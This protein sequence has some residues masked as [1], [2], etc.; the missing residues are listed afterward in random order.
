[1]ALIKCSECGTEVSDK[2]A[3]CIKC[4]APIYA[5]SKATAA[6]LNQPK[7]KSRLLKVVAWAFG[8][9]VVFSVLAGI[10][11]KSNPDQ[12]A[13]ADPAPQQPAQAPPAVPATVETPAPAPALY[14]KSDDGKPCLKDDLQCRGN[15][16][17]VAASVY[18]K[19]PVERLASHSVKW[20]DG[21]FELKFS[22]FRFTDGAHETLTYIGDKAEFQNGFGAFTPMIYQCDLASDG[23]TVLGVRAV[24]GRLPA[25]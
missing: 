3:A 1:M 14:G 12:P 11:S 9:F 5:Q 21:T 25:N 7:R 8:I 18:C 2:A 15:A 4:G 22:R 20:T 17:V 6:P 24:D 10:F 19:D 13:D 16:G 23:K